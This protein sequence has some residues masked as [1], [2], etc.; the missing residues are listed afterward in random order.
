MGLID[1]V[2]VPVI[3]IKHFQLH[4]CYHNYSGSTVN[5]TRVEWVPGRSRDQ[6]AVGHDG[7]CELIQPQ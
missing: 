1:Y 4:T 3:E 5:P 6:V 7:P 2:M